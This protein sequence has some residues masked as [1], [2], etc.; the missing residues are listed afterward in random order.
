MPN[1]LEILEVIK[2]NLI[3]EVLSFYFLLLFGLL[4]VSI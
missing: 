4:I 1:D 2:E 3:L